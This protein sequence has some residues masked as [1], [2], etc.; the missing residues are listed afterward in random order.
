MVPPEK[1]RERMGLCENCPHFNVSED[2]I[3]T[4]D[5]CLCY[6]SLKTVFA[7]ETCPDGRW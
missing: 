3:A 7:R 4:C 2:G 5:L 1:V 6:L